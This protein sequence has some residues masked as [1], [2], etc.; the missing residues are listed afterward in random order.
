MAQGAGMKVIEEREAGIGV[1]Q[2]A[3][4]QGSGMMQQKEIIGGCGVVRVNMSPETL[5]CS[6]I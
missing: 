5:S 6:K 3:K 2:W 1:Q 4:Q